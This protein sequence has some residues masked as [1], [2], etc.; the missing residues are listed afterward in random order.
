M[1]QDPPARCSSFKLDQYRLNNRIALIA[2]EQVLHLIN[3]E[4][5]NNSSEATQM[6]VRAL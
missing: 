2:A 3:K 5:C 1:K 4:K 6:H